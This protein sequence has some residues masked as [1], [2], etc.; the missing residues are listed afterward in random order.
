MRKHKLFSNKLQR[1]IKKY[2]LIIHSICN[3]KYNKKNKKHKRKASKY[4]IEC[5][6]AIKSNSSLKYKQERLKIISSNIYNF[7]LMTKEIEE[8]L[9]HIMMPFIFGENNENEG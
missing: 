4:A 6:D 5:E 7:S 1:V 9:N 2:Y 3:E 8:E